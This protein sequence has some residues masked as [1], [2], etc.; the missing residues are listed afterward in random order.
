MTPR[1]SA[2]FGLVDQHAALD[3]RGH[4]DGMTG[5]SGRDGSPSMPPGRVEP[6]CPVQRAARTP[7]LT[8]G[9]LLLRDSWEGRQ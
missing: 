4:G 6:T 1:S 9:L 3:S 8:L 2:G 7:S 5:L